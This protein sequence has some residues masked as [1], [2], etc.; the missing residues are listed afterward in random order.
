M[1]AGGWVWHG[2]PGWWGG[3]GAPPIIRQRSS[4]CPSDPAMGTSG[5]TL[6]STFGGDGGSNPQAGPGRGEQSKDNGIL[7]GALSRAKTPG[8]KKGLAPSFPRLKRCPPGLQ[9]EQSHPDTMHS[10]ERRV[11]AGTLHYG[12]STYVVRRGI[13]LGQQQVS[14]EARHARHRTEEAGNL[15]RSYGLREAGTCNRQKKLS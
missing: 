9:K 15:K 4:G 7:C 12:G 11:W 1:G 14:E 2:A 13:S 3:R 5:F 6:P 10:G 8:A